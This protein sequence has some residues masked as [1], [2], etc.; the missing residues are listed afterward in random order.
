MAGAFDENGLGAII[1]NS[2]GV[3]FAFRSDAYSEKFGEKYWENAVEAATRDMISALTA[4]T[5]V[6][7]L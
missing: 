3:I 7:K 1:N 2:R 5:T 4:E 6:S